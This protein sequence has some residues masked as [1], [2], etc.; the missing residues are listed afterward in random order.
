V[1]NRDYVIGRS[2]WSRQLNLALQK[3]QPGDRLIVPTEQARRLA[4]ATAEA[5]GKTGIEI[6]IADRLEG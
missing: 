5:G 2:N 3:A 6:V 1:S 4:E